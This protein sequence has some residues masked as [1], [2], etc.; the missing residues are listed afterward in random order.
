MKK[1]LRPRLL[2][3]FLVAIAM[4]VACPAAFAQAVPTNTARLPGAGQL[5][6]EIPRQP[7]TAARSDL[8]LRMLHKPHP[9]A[10]A[11]R[12]FLVRRIRITGNT[13]LATAT[14]HA[15]VAG[16]EGE[17]LTLA[18]L[19]GLADRISD[20]YRKAG[21]PLARAY[22]PAQTLRDGVVRIAVVEARYGE[23]ELHNASSVAKSTLAATLAPLQPGQPVR[24]RPLER[25][26]LLLSDIPGARTASVIRPGAEAGTSDLIV[27]V[28]P[29]PRY[30]GTVQLDDFGN[31]YT[32][33]TRLAA[34]LGIND[35]S[36]HG[37]RLNLGGLSSGSGM[38]YVHGDYDIRLN[39]QG[40]TLRMGVSSL[41]YRLGGDLLRLGAHGSAVTGSLV[42]NH[43]LVRTTV[44]N[45]YG[46]LE[47]DHKLL[48]DDIDVARIDNDRQDNVWTATLAGDE[49][50]SR[51][52]TNYS[53]GV[54]HGKIA[55][56]DALAA[57]VDRITADTQGSY[58]SVRLSAARLQT[59]DSRNAL[60]LGIAWQRANKNLDTS[61]QFFLGGPN[62]ARGYASGVLAGSQGSMLTAEFRH[63]FSLPGTPGNLQAIVF[64]DSGRV[65]MYKRAFQAGPNHARASDAGLGLHWAG[66]G[67]WV[68]RASAAKPIGSVPDMLAPKDSST[69]VWVSVLKGFD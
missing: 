49:R 55:Y 14:L 66:P 15:L 62:S 29:A 28:T 18:D 43:P 8:D 67:N 60:Y 27:D 34:N 54:S 32:G 17:K 57:F 1:T 35:P 44:A 56:G 59:L 25:S 13:L 7:S 47:F 46:Q 22:V 51:G 50:D 36:H 26:L 16:S 2:T 38:N 65:Q 9:E 12:P 45:L 4:V 53:L 52:V 11:S 6:Q 30:T 69:Q 39:G 24:N 48:R 20:A 63:D 42:L 10:P 37:D 23:V 19:Y 33:R 5:L 31:R 21:Y 41:H 58:T 61:E 68:V 3:V 40:T 64:V